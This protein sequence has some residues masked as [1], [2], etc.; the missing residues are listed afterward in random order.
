MLSLLYNIVRR[1]DNLPS[2]Y[3]ADNAI[4]IVLPFTLCPLGKIGLLAK[5]MLSFL[6]H[7]IKDDQLSSLKLETDEINFFATSLS[8]AVESDTSVLE[9][10]MSELES[11]VSLLESD[12]PVDVSA[13][14]ADTSTL[15]SALDMDTSALESS[16]LETDTFALESDTSALESD[17]S[18]L[19]F[20]AEEI[21]TILINLSTTPGNQCALPS[22]EILLAVERVVQGS[23]RDLQ[24]LAIHLLSNFTAGLRADLAIP[25]SIVSTL[26]ALRDDLS[27]GMGPLAHCLLQS[28]HQEGKNFSVGIPSVL[29]L[30]IH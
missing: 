3:P 11:N 9:P 29:P 8:S 18:T 16:E 28:I 20:T 6:Q 26:C 23:D 10:D 24:C 30:Q 27:T 2:V 13:L 7:L 4:K 5:C 1:K 15:Q 17:T 22:K 25:E 21:L 19:G 14:E 12:V